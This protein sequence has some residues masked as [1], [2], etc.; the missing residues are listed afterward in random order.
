MCPA[1]QEEILDVTRALHL[2][3][4]DDPRFS[5]RDGIE[6]NY[7]DFAE[8]VHKT[9]K[10]LQGR[11]I[12]E[13]LNIEALLRSPQSKK[14][15]PLFQFFLRRSAV[16]WR[17]VNDSMVW[18]VLGV[19][20]GH[21]IRRLSHHKPRPILA[22]ANLN[23]MRRLLDEINSDPLSI[24]LWSDA[25]SCVDVGDLVCRSYSGGLTGIVEVKEGKVNEAIS[26]TLSSISETL[27]SKPLNIAEGVKHIEA[28]AQRYGIKAVKQLERMLRQ[29][30]TL[31]Q[32][33]TLFEKDAG[34]DPYFKRHVVVR[35]SQVT[36]RSYDGVLS[37][38]IERS[39]SGR[40][41]ENIDRCLWVYVDRLSAK[42]HRELLKN[43]S[44]EVFRRAVHV[45][46]WTKERYGADLLQSVVSLDSNL[47]APTALPIFHRGFEAEMIRDVIIGP[48]RQCVLLYFDWVE[49]ARL[50]QE[51]GASLT[52]STEKVARAQH[53]KPL[54]QRPI[55]IGG[56]I[57]I[58]SHPD[59]KTPIT[60]QSKVDR[61]LFEGILPSTIAAQYVEML[62]W[63][64]PDG[65][66]EQN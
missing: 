6:A 46:E 26:D 16:I 55:I 60:G 30:Q 64:T 31:D 52:W 20:N 53:S 39:S 59:C 62:K 23:S 40:V 54:H 9:Y 38:I 37:S 48:L 25:T 36:D 44:E 49:Y 65:E 34:F 27:R 1:I 7:S 15:P 11:A 45:R 24:A 10:R 58:V 28:L 35:E 29:Q 56:R 21:L 4:G 18:A 63:N 57:P 17:R 42:T 3:A 66:S 19:N 12:D 61:V 5:S 14:L 51:R 8:S 33:L 13:I 22:E 43:F 2:P 50:F 41:I 47:Y 32:V